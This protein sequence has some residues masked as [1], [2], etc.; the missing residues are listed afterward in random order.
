MPGPRFG[1][2]AGLRATS[3]FGAVATVVDGL[4]FHS[5]REA[6]YYAQYKILE[7]AGK[8]GNL[9]LQPKFPVHINGVKVCNV[10]LDFAF[11]DYYANARCAIDVKGMDTPISRLKRKMLE[12]AYPGVKVEIVR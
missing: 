6:H 5:K 9:E 7:R 1:R 11:F 4:T 3:K 10:I 12:A 2:F 8:I